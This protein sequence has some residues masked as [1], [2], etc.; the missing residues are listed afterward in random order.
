MWVGE[1]GDDSCPVKAIVDYAKR[2]GSAPGPFFKLEGGTPLTKNRFVEK[3][4]EAMTR[5]GIDTSRYSGHSFRIGA[6]MSAAAVSL[7]DS[8]IQALGRWSSPAFSRYIRT[9]REELS[10]HTQ[11]LARLGRR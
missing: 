4:R 11:T 7:E 8:V 2:R 3:V 6:A 9:P 10:R 5:A 1:S